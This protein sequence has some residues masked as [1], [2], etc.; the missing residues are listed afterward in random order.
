MKPVYALFLLLAACAAPN[1]LTSPSV[2]ETPTAAIEAVPLVLNGEMIQG[3]MIIGETAPGAMVRLDGKNVRIAPDGH[4]VFGF[5]RDFEGPATLAIALNGAERVERLD[6]GKREYKIQR[7]DG[8][9]PKMVTP[10]AEVLDRIKREGALIAAARARDTPG[11]WFL[12]DFIWPAN[13]IISGV[14]GSQ[15]ILNGEPRRPHFGLDVAA[16]AG[17]PVFE[18]AGGMVALAEADLYFTGGTIMI[19]HG[20]GVTS[21]YMHLQSVEVSVGQTVAQGDRIGTIGSTGR[22]TGPHLDWRMNWFSERLDPAFLVS[23]TPDPLAQD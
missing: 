3:A 7:I 1:N 21:V 11:G 4:F 23:P 10:P 9:P 20:H 19:D 6:V 14:Y 13:G 2:D 16:P 5:G 18:V 22:A 12:A 8:L 17:T 15:R